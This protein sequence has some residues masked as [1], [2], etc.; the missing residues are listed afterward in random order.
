MLV[1]R[2][3]R[4][5]PPTPSKYCMSKATKGRAGR[6]RRQSHNR[7]MPKAPSQGERAPDMTP[8]LRENRDPSAIVVTLPLPRGTREL[9]CP[10]FPA[11]M[12]FGCALALLTAAGW[13]VYDYSRLVTLTIDDARTINQLADRNQALSSESERLREQIARLSYRMKVAAA[14]RRWRGEH[15]QRMQQLSAWGDAPVRPGGEGEEW[16][17][18][19]DI[20]ER[21]VHQGAGRTRAGV[22]GAERNCS[23]TKGECQRNSDKTSGRRSVSGKARTGGGFSQGRGT[24]TRLTSSGSV[25]SNGSTLPHLPSL[26]AGVSPLY[27]PT[28][29]RVTSHFGIRSSPFRRGRQMHEG[30]DIDCTGG[31]PIR[32]AGAGTVLS[33]GRHR[34]YGLV[35]DVAHGG[36]LTTRYAHLSA[37]S[38]SVGA[39]VAHGTILG[40]C[41]S[42][43]RSTG[44]HLHFEVRHNG[45]P[46]DPRRYLFQDKRLPMR[47]DQRV[48]VA[49]INETD[50][51]SKTTRR[52][53]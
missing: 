14:S 4:V 25:Q 35:V 20:E 29:G 21:V 13:A 44:A 36:S 28:A 8:L 3:Y 40:Q 52:I 37:A 53:G 16:T 24:F 33:V 17:A 1:Q 48:Q 32:A 9:I 12:F 7:S 11:S 38:V 42:S 50:T 2:P 39:P 51:K 27:L 34:S 45:A 26:R 30:M 47:E 43:G 23:V 49:S 15:E 31:A 5:S 18:W 41:G 19:G 10:R 6:S 22:G 46:V